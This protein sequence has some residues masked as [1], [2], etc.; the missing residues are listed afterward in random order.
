MS[1][2]ISAQLALGQR[3]R[4]TGTSALCWKEKEDLLISIKF[5]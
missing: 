3:L 1:G 4:G 2:D 5:K